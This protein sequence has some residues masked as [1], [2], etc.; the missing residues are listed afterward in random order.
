MVCRG[1]LQQAAPRPLK[2]QEICDSIEK[3]QPWRIS[4]CRGADKRMAA[5]VTGASAVSS[6]WLSFKS[7]LLEKYTM[8]SITV[9]SIQK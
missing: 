6:A 4:K 5:Q 1:A 3:Y 9:T 2:V 7:Y 8:D